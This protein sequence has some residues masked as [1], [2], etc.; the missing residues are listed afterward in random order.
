MRKIQKFAIVG[1]TVTALLVGGVAYAAWT[2][3]G[4]GVGH[5][6]AAGTPVD[7]GV[8]GTDVGG[9]YPTGS[10]TQNVTVTN[11]NPYAVKLSDLTPNNATITSNVPACT[12]SSVTAATVLD[13]TVLAATTGSK[14]IPVTVSMDNTA[15]DACQ[16]AI[17][18]I[19]YTA[20]G[21]S[22]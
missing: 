9:L 21:L 3:S 18:T 6:T 16:S 10:V 19:S 4:T 5:V 2:S 12:A 14:T 7:L 15:N 11:T 1:G 17:F 22:N 8:S 13:T 20:H